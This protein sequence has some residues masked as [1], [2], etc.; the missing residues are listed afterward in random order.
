MHLLLVVFSLWA[1]LAQGQI[2]S[3]GGPPCSQNGTLR[4]SGRAE[5]NGVPDL[6]TVSLTIFSGQP[7]ASDARDM[8]A[9]ATVQVLDALA[10]INGLSSNAISTQSVE[11]TPS[12]STDREG[13]QTPNG[14]IFRQTLQVE[15]ANVTGDQLASVIDTAVTA[16]GDNVTV[17]GIQTRLSPQL[18]RLVMNQARR[19]AVDDAFDTA[20]LL[21]QAAGVDITAIQSISDS[22]TSPTPFPASYGGPAAAREAA[23]PTTVNVADTRVTAMLDVTFTICGAR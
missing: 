8:V 16:G 3:N 23:P 4:V 14:F 20:A 10:G 18:E 5:A 9:Q 11:L 6:G 7:S 13:N 15:V 22:N 21:A 19:A 17:E 1:A 2:M 12:Y